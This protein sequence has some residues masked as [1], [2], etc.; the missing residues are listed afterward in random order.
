MRDEV[1]GQ[2]EFT[3]NGEGF[4]FAIADDLEFGAVG[5]IELA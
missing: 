3:A 2:D 5:D 4:I 1:Q